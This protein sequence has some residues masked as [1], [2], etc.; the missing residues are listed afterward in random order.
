VTDTVHPFRVAVP[1]D[2]V[3][4]LYDRLARTRWPDELADAGWDYG[5]PTSY[6]KELVDYLQRGY[7]W[8]AAETSL[9]AWPQFTTEIDGASI[10]FAHLRSPEP[11]ALALIMTHGWPGSIVEFQ[12]VAGPLIDP[13]AHGGNPRD[14]FHLVLPSLPGFGFSGPTTERGWDFR[15]MARAFAVLME[16]LGYDS[17]AAHGGDWGW[18]ISRELGRIRPDNV[19]GIHLNLIGSYV[20]AE[21]TESELAGLNDADRAETLASWER[22]RAW[23]SEEQGYGVLQASRPQTLAY[24]L[25][26]SPVGQLAWIVEKFRSWT[27]SAD[28]PEDAVDRDQMLTNALL[29]W[30]T[31]T[32]GS[33][34]RIYY[35][36][37]HAAPDASPIDAPSRT[38][39]ALALFPAENFLPVRHL[40]E[41]VNNIARWTRFERGGHFA[42]MEVPDLLVDDIRAFFRTLRSAD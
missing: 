36:R 23:E 35:E 3:D 38:P 19:V 26:D 10:H 33:S 17:Y 16:R 8:R 7:D 9:N 18:L 5:V 29:Y 1:Q 6:L 12:K 32:A 21:P 15:R 25:T 37:A 22:T 14:A 27:D 40:A 28:V 34:A 11:D 13:R 20:V 2:R 24:A 39:T 31:G 30:F 4:D 42:A 41:K